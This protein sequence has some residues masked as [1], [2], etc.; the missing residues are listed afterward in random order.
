ML[1]V[2]ELTRHDIDE[3]DTM[4]D[5]GMVAL[6]EA[7]GKIMESEHAD[8]SRESVALAVREV[9]EL[10]ASELGRRGAVSALAGAGDVSQ[11]IA[12]GRDTRVG[13]IELAIPKLWQGQLPAQFPQRAQ[14][15][16]A[17]AARAG[18]GGLHEWNGW[19]TSPTSRPPRLA[20]RG[21]LFTP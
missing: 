11:G 6:R 18:D 15:Q 5:A 4:A 10:E 2:D 8:L 12:S 3:E 20:K 21:S 17:G 13:T 19:L 14:A 9:M 16:R 1:R 7:L